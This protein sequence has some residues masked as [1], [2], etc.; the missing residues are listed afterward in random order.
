MADQFEQSAAQAVVVAL[1]VE[2]G[3]QFVDVLGGA[4]Q[5]RPES[6]LL[7]LRIVASHEP[8]RAVELPRHLAKVSPIGRAVGT[9]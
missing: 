8:Y 6:V 5:Q 2:C 3:D 7:G 4:G 1:G 9:D